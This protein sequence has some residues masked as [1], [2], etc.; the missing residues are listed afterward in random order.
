MKG[1]FMKRSIWLSFFLSVITVFMLTGCDTRR[2]DNTVDDRTVITD[3]DNATRDNTDNEIGTGTDADRDWMV[4][5]NNRDY[6]YNERD[7]FKSDIDRA[8]DRLDERIDMIEDR[9][10]DATGDMKDAYEK[11]IEDLKAKRDNVEKRMDGFDE[12]TDANWNQ[13]KS[14][15]RT[16]W[17]DVKSDVDQF[18]KEL[19]VD[20]NTTETKTY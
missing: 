5:E 11:R 13:F 2:D 17:M 8:M 15:I 3:D 18:G 19:K 7:A 12:V 14:N 10:D 4:F 9:A 20:F 16:A 1:I 6:T